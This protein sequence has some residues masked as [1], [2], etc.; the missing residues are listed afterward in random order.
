[1]RTIRRSNIVLYTKPY[2]SLYKLAPSI[3]HIH[4]RKNSSVRCSEKAFRCLS[5]LNVTF[6]SLYYLFCTNLKSWYCNIPYSNCY[7]LSSAHVCCQISLSN[8]NVHFI[9]T[10]LQSRDCND[11]FTKFITYCTH[12]NLRRDILRLI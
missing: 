9:C 7:E 8:K 11:R 10:V 3:R 2:K 6:C 4:F 5:N 12:R 1:M